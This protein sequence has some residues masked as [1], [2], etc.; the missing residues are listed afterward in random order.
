M[1]RTFVLSPR[2]TI[3]IEGVSKAWIRVAFH[4]TDLGNYETKSMTRWLVSDKPLRPTQRH[5]VEEFMRKGRTTWLME[6]GSNYERND[7][8]EIE[9]CHQWLYRLFD[10]IPQKLYFRQV[11]MV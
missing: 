10:D 11:R 5:T 6:P 1:I 7:G 4:K 9:I 2:G 3:K 8:I